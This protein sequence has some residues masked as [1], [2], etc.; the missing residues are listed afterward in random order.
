MREIKFVANY[1]NQDWFI[2][3]VKPKRKNHQG[4]YKCQGYIMRLVNHHPH[5]TKRGYVPEHRLMMEQRLKR[6]L[7]PRVELVHHIDGNRSNNEL[8]N[9]KLTSPIEHPRGHVGERN[10]LGQFLTTEPIFQEIKIRLFNTNTKECRPYT[11]AELIGKTFRRGQFSFRGRFTGLKDKN[12]KE[13]YEGDILFDKWD[14]KKREDPTY[15]CGNKG[16]VEWHED[17]GAWSWEHGE[18]WG[19]IESS[20]VEVIGN[21]WENPDLLEK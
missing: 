2:A 20:W 15:C 4:Y 12:G 3:T 18:E 14:T 7:I 9:L 1:A 21:I 16:I 10:K 8:S 6:F 13:I 19:M 5:E 17:M 11:L